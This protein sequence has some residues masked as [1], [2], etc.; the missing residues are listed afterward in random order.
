MILKEKMVVKMT[1]G[2]NHIVQ[3]VKNIK[4]KEVALLLSLEDFVLRFAIEDENSEGVGLKFQT[5]KEKILK[6]AEEFDKV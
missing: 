6:I 3:K 4:G 1:D 2:I 5:D